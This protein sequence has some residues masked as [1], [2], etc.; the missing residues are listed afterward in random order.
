MLLQLGGRGAVR[1]TGSLEVGEGLGEGCSISYELLVSRAT[2]KQNQ[3]S[4]YADFES[5]LIS[6]FAQR[7]PEIIHRSC[8]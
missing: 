5:K 3:P 6:V 4:K 2:A 8:G 7:N 1:S